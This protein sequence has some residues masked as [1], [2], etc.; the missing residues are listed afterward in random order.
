M[1]IY[2]KYPLENTGGYVRRRLVGVCDGFAS[3]WAWKCTDCGSGAIDRDGVWFTSQQDAEEALWEHA[4][5]CRN[6]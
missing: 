4:E 1:K 3:A 5:E 2:D 6:G